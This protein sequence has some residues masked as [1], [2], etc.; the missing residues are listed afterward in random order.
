MRNMHSFIRFEKGWTTNVPKTL[1]NMLK[2]NQSKDD[3]MYDSSI[4]LDEII[5]LI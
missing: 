4:N 2:K 1:K 5:V 3:C